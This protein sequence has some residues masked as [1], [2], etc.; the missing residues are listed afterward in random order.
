MRISYRITSQTLFTFLGLF[1][2]VVTL[3]PTV[4][5]DNDVEFKIGTSG[6]P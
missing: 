2:V 4:P 6:N 1:H 5:Y 3:Y